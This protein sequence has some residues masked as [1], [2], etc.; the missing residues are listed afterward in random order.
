MLINRWM[1]KE[2][3]V[4][5][6]MCDGILLSYKT[7]EMLPFAT[8]WMDIESIM[9]SETSQM[10]KTNTIW[11]HLYVESKKQMNKYNKTETEL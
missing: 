10:R 5:V 8:T 9:L 4:R 2:D 1:D 11:F 3:V 6:C 7:N